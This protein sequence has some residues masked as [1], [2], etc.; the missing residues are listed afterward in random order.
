MDNLSK[1][2]GWNPDEFSVPPMAGGHGAATIAT[3]EGTEREQPLDIE[4]KHPKRRIG[5][6][7]RQVLLAL[8]V[9]GSLALG[10]TLYAA[11]VPA[12]PVSAATTTDEAAEEEF[13]EEEEAPRNRGGRA[14][15]ARAG[16]SGGSGRGSYSAQGDVSDVF[17]RPRENETQS[18]W[19]RR[20]PLYCV[21]RYQAPSR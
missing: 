13:A 20:V 3:A 4:F 14:A 18:A 11:A 21:D 19:R 6:Q 16:S 15:P 12:A 17:C 1:G 8:G 7:V 9:V 10:V 5:Q 2:D